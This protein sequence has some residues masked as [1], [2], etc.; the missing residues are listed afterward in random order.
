MKQRSILFLTICML[1]VGL[2]ATAAHADV[3]YEY[4]F[5]GVDTAGNALSFT[6]SN[7]TGFLTGP[8]Y[9]TASQLNSCTDCLA[10]SGPVVYFNPNVS[11]YGDVLQI[12]SANGATNTF[13]FDYNSFAGVGAYGTD[14]FQDGSLYVSMP[15]PSSAGFTIA[16]VVMLAGLAFFRRKPVTGNLLA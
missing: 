8:T 11:A 1:T 3:N 5:Y 6:Y 9:F 15:E 2:M 7:N 4:D 14:W 10:T 13:V 16:G 12:L